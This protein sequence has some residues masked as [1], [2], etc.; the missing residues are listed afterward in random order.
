MTVKLA[1]GLHA[2]RVLVAHGKSDFNA[3]ERNGC[4]ALGMAVMHKR[5][6]SVRLLLPLSSLHIRSYRGLLPIHGCAVYGDAEIMNLL[7]D[8]GCMPTLED[9]AGTEQSLPLHLAC[10]VGNAETATV[11][12]KRGAARSSR[13]ATG[14][15]PLMVAAK[16]GHQQLAILICGRPDKPKVSEEEVNAEDNAGNTALCYA[17]KFGDEKLCGMLVSRG[18]RITE[19][20]KAFGK[21]HPKNKALLDGRGIAA[22][23]GAAVPG[24]ICERCGKQEGP[25]VRL[26]AC[27]ACLSARY[28][29]RECASACCVRVLWAELTASPL[30]PLGRPTRRLQEPQSGL[31]AGD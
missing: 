26:R 19:K 6:E 2:L 5:P 20:A 30:L 17:A 21:A 16:N 1:E 8:N 25:A 28:C 23:G 18:A 3:R 14:E 9:P 12:L 4:N 15:T 22:A 11:L 27:S 13:S 29:G 24:T 7:L 31:Q 10:S